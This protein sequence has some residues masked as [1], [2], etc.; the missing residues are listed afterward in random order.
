MTSP[1][2]MAAIKAGMAGVYERNAAAWDAGRDTSLRERDWLTRLLTGLPERAKILDLGCGAGRPLAGYLADLGHE[3]TGVDASPTM[4]QHARRNV[5]EADFQVM[6]M[7]HLDLENTFDAILS[8]DAFFHL[9]PQ[10]QR[11]VLP[12]ILDHLAP[13]GNMMLTVGDAEGEVAGTVAGEP[14]YHGS[15]DTT[16]YRAILHRAGFAEVIYTPNDPTVLGRYVLL[17]LGKGDQ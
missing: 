16:E 5:P 6:D 3:V 2:E 17:A 13:G 11:S 4:I 10:E 1:E 15:L 12:V 14:V 7:R 8:W 9:S